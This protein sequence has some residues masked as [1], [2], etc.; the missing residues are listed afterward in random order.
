MLVQLILRINRTGEVSPRDPASPGASLP[1]ER[2]GRRAVVREADPISQAR[3]QRR[4]AASKQK[5]EK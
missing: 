1:I 4:L 5:P 3:R 2:A